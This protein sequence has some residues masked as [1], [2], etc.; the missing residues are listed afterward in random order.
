MYNLKT[1]IQTVAV[2]EN[3]QVMV[4]ILKSPAVCGLTVVAVMDKDARVWNRE[5]GICTVATHYTL[6]EDDLFA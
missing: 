4:L 2:K 5:T 1:K 3:N 6:R